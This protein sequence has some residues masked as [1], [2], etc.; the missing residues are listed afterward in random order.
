M[1]LN[2]TTDYAIRTVLC[3]GSDGKSRTAN[4]IAEEMCIPEK[5][6]IKVL[7][8]LRKGGIIKSFSGYGGGYQLKRQFSTILLGDVLELTEKTMKIN[9]CLEEHSSCNRHAAEVC[10][11]HKFY[12]DFQEDIQKRW[13]SVPLKNILDSYQV[14]D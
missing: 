13:L 4:E 6:L 2:T 5:Y 11:M 8:K 12:G 1:Q 7:S 9:K 14:E 10:A 3:L